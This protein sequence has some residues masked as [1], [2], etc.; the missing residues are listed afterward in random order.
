MGTGSSKG[1]FASEQVPNKQTKDICFFS[2]FCPPTRTTRHYDPL[3]SP[4]SPHP[5]LA[6]NGKGTGKARKQIYGG[7]EAEDSSRSLMSSGT[8]SRNSQNSRHSH[9]SKS[10][11][12]NINSNSSSKSNGN[13]IIYEGEDSEQMLLKKYQMCEVLGVGSTSICH[14]CVDRNTGIPYACKIIDKEQIEQRFEGMMEQF[15]S[16]IEALKSLHHPNIIKLYNVYTTKK[17]IYIVMELM[18]G[19]E[20]FDYVVQKGTLTEAEAST[21]VRM[22]TDALVYMHE[23]NIIHRDL[24]PENLLLTRKPNSVYDIEVKIIDFG[25]SKVSSLSI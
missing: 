18:A 23:K 15:H 5:R 12:R 22:V 11:Y 1:P 19:G 2:M 9:A 16:E 8:N 3:G 7:L 17:R 20:L 14:R 6:S 25:L 13:S 24:K 4:L 21:I 10:P